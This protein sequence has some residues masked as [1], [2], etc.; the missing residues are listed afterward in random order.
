MKKMNQN[1]QHKKR[2]T[3]GLLYSVIVVGI[4]VIANLIVREIPVQLTQFDTS[5]NAIYTFSDETKNTLK[6]VNKNIDIYLIAESGTEDDVIEKTLLRYASESEYLS[7]EVIDP[8]LNVS[9]VKKYTDAT[10]SNNSVILSDGDR[11]VVVDKMEIYLYDVS[12][13]QFSD[14]TGNEN[15]TY[16]VYYNCEGAITDA[17][18]QLMDDSRYVIYVLEGH[19]ELVLSENIQSELYADNYEIRTFS[20]LNDNEDWKEA[21]FLLVNA[22]QK[23]IPDAELQKLRDYL[24]KGGKLML[25]TD[26]ASSSFTNWMS[27]CKDYGVEG[28]EGIIFEADANSCIDGYANYLLPQILRHDITDPLVRYGYRVL[29]PSAHGIVKTAEKGESVSVIGLLKTSSDAYI[30][31]DVVN[32]ESISPTES[33]RKG[34]FYLGVAITQDLKDEQ[35]TR[36][37]WYSSSQFLDDTVNSAVSGVHTDLMMNSINFLTEKDSDYSIRYKYVYNNVLVFSSGEKML[38]NIVIIAVIPISILSFS[39]VR[40]Y[41]RKRK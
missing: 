38:W 41:K 14:V 35:Q 2:T 33:D 22:P 23:D 8:L 13:L 18:K 29:F 10:V 28:V 5:N 12:A 20:L 1:R 24:S 6:R 11:A 26:Y 3:L 34:P 17:I 4:F 16:T 31:N 37:V 39:L 19:G 7:F 27:L 25:I 9:F 30:K 40:F 36:V 32:L 21:S 15:A